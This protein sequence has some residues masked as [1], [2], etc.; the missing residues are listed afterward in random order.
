MYRVSVRQGFDGERSII[1][2]EHVNGVKLLSGKI[3]K[4]VGKIESFIF[5]IS[6]LSNQYNNFHFQ[7]TFV[8]VVDTRTSRVLFDGRVLETNDGMDGNENI[9]EEVTCESLLAFL[10]DSSQ[11]F[12]ALTNNELTKFF[13]NMV[14]VHNRQVETYKQFTVGNV[15]VKSPSDNVYKAVDETKDTYDNIQEKL[16]EK[17]GGE[18]QVRNEK[19]KLYLDYISQ[20]GR[21]ANQEICLT[22]NLIASKR[23]IEQNGLYSIIKPLGATIEDNKQGGTDVSK[24]RLNIKT[25]NNGSLFLYNQKLLDLIG[26]ITVAVV[27]DDV[28][29]AT[30]LKA[31][32]LN[33]LNNQSMAKLQYDITAVDLNL[34]P[35][36][37]IDEFEVGNSYRIINELQGIDDTMRV[38]SMN[39]DIVNVLSSS[40]TLGEKALTQEQLFANLKKQSESSKDIRDKVKQHDS[41]ISDLVVKQTSVETKLTALRT[42]F[43][44]ANVSGINNSLIA[45]EAKMTQLREDFDEFS[46]EQRL[47]NVDIENRLEEIEKGGTAN[48]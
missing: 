46:I 32:G 14:N 44:G 10:H 18:L 40:L 35:N 31:K 30:N 28:K 47:T 20:V 7:T 37:R 24:P 13:K 39:I 9:I 21:I 34:L 27:W 15:T 33:E 16:I 11:D 48:E 25:V 43:D 19:G 2:S 38:V 45:L 17:Y 1:H 41:E 36:S 3:T 42:E 5:Q 6:P 23:S 22:T 4:E 8:D 29:E 26:R 12:Y